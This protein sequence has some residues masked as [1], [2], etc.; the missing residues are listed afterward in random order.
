MCKLLIAG[1]SFNTVLDAVD[2]AGSL[3]PSYYNFNLR[4]LL[5]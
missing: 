5:I 3:C 1:F 4:Q 2:T